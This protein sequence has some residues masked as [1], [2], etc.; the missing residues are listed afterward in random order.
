MLKTFSHLSDSI[1][2]NDRVKGVVQNHKQV[3]ESATTSYVATLANT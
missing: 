1:Q 3:A 2:G